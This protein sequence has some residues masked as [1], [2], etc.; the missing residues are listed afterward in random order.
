MQG[1]LNLICEEHTLY[2]VIRNQ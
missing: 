2:T 1:A